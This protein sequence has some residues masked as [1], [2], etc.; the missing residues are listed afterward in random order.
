MA[1]MLRTKA[2][3]R[4]GFASCILVPHSAT[5]CLLCPEL[6]KYENQASQSAANL[7]CNETKE[8]KTHMLLLSNNERTIKKIKEQITLCIMGYETITGGGRWRM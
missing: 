6:V 3:D 5:H 1:L 8:S 2:G 4:F 7:M